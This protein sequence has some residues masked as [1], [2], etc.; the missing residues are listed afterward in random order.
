VKSITGEAPRFCRPPGGD[1]DV[2]VMRAAEAQGLTTV[3]W[4]DDPGDYASPGDA[5]IETRVLDH[6]GN[7]GIIL[8]HDGVQQTVDVLPQIVEHLKR[9]GF[10]FVTVAEMEVQTG[11]K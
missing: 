6:I 9:R 4:T 5:K 1:Y 8:I 10:R 7:G 3:L 2:V 11:R